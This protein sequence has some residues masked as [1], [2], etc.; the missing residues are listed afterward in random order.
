MLLLKIRKIRDGREF[1]MR[2]CPQKVSQK[3]REVGVIGQKVK[4]WL[5][6][7]ETDELVEIQ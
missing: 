7:N 1:P 6:L 5:F 2:G 4:G 3:L